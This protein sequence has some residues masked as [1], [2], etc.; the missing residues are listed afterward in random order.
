MINQDLRLVRYKPDKREGVNPSSNDPSVKKVIAVCSRVYDLGLVDSYKQGGTIAGSHGNVSARIQDSEKT[1]PYDVHFITASALPSKQHLTADDLSRVLKMEM[2]KSADEQG[3][4]PYVGEKV[5]SSETIYHSFFYE[6]EPE[7]LGIIH[8]HFDAKLMYADP[9]REHILEEA[10]RELGII[11][12]NRYGVEGTVDLP[13]SVRD[14]LAPGQWKYLTVVWKDHY[15]RDA[16]IEPEHQRRIGMSVMDVDLD[17]ALER[18]ERF[19]YGLID[20]GKRRYGGVTFQEQ[21]PRFAALR[22]EE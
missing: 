11:S 21:F 22:P 14:V 9:A 17:R 6:Q 7:I 1:A 20:A 5:A 19:V 2:P 18:T 8:G 10:W 4:V 12:S 16:T 13:L 15:P 3:K